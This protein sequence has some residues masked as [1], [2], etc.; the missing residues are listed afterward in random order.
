M[1][2][3]TWS[4]LTNPSNASAATIDRVKADATGC[5]TSAT[6]AP[7]FD[8]GNTFATTATAT[9][10]S[11]ATLTF[12]GLTAH[13]MPIS[14]GQAVSCSWCTTGLFVVSMSN[15][16]TQDARAGMGQIGAANN[17]FTVV[18][19]AAPGVTGTGHAFTFGCS[20]TAGP[21]ELHRYCVHDPDCRDLRYSGVAGDVRRE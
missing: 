12:N 2:A 20:G 21:L 19:N 8:V 9:A 11:S 14:A 18:L 16:P 4:G 13:T 1:A 17:G 15:P 10:I 6:T 7:C 5:D 3:L